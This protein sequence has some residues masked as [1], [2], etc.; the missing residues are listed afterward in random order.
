M[1]SKI[2]SKAI[3]LN[4]GERKTLLAY[5]FMLSLEPVTCTSEPSDHRSFWDK[6]YVNSGPTEKKCVSTHT[7]E[8]VACTLKRPW[9]W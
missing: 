6:D 9:V 7:L 4:W 2:K 5:T 3:C 1:Y 8:S